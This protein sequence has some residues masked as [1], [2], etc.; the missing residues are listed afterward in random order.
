M[1]LDL[2]EYTLALEEAFGV[3]PLASRSRTTRPRSSSVRAELG[4]N[5]ALRAH[6]D[7]WW[8]RVL[9][10]R[11]TTVGEVAEQWAV[12]APRTLKPEGEAWSRQ[13]VREVVVGRLERECPVPAAEY[14]LDSHFV[15]DMGLS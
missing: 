15:R 12:Y 13:E 6:G 7:S 5:R 9:G 8:R 11:G 4:A 10:E 1:G 3:R 14:T 2:V